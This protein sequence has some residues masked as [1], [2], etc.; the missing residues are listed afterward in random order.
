MRQ[1]LIEA[2]EEGFSR[3]TGDSGVMSSNEKVVVGNN[4]ASR[5]QLVNRK[6]RGDF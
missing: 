4:D 3:R 6:L 1:K 2:S 5:S